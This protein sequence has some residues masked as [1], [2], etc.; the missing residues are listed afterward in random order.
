[1]KGVV[2][3]DLGPLQVAKSFINVNATRLFCTTNVIHDLLY[4]GL[5]WSRWQA[6]VNPRRQIST[7]DG[8]LDANLTILIHELAHGL[9][10]RLAG[11]SDDTDRGR[12]EAGE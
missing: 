12:A 2:N 3:L 11:G 7:S 6:A 1:M 9:S 8:D 4:G 5:I 10:S